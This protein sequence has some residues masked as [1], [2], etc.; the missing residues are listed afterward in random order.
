[1]VLT[2]RD[3]PPGPPPSPTALWVSPV[4]NLAGVARHILDVARVGLPG[5]RL[6]VA[7][8]A[9]PLVGELTALG[10]AVVTIDV[11]RPLPAAL[12]QLRGVIT[13]LRPDV[14]HSHLAKADLLCAMACAG[15]DVKLVSTEHHVPEE[16]RVFHA[17]PARA[18]SRALAHHLRL[19]RFDHV[20]AVS[21]S[22]RRDMRRHWRTKTPITVVLNGVERPAAI[23]ERSP[24]LRILSLGRLDMEK[25]VAMSLRAFALV[26][27]EHP[28]ATM[29]VAGSGPLDAALRERA[30]RLGIADAV[31]FAG[32]VDAGEAMA[33]HDVLVQPS[34]AE[35]LSY[36]LLDAVAHGMGVVASDVG[37]NPEIVPGHCLVT[38]GDGAV[39]EARM[40]RV[41]VEQGLQI[42][43]RPS[44]PE[45]IPTPRE[46]T[47]QI[48]ERY[49]AL[50]WSVGA[51]AR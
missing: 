14:V 16:P 9:G 38:P 13:R 3:A 43:R 23:Q 37:G 31:T 48:V 40:A 12:A 17:T 20:L 49:A 15:L 7:A 39:H 11:D 45:A 34:L 10:C 35:N 42:E 21:E 50:E 5:W 26:R 1:M 18:R 28:E 24:G 46:M 44:L 27:S 22:T 29:T 47:E 25:N 36:T 33:T 19:R 4:S 51:E 32:F 30:D 8:P 2:G 41:I 6:V